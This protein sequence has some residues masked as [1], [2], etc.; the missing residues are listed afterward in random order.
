M[1]FRMKWEVTCI[2]Q[3]NSYIQHLSVDRY[4]FRSSPLTTLP[5]GFTPLM[6]ASYQGYCSV[7][8]TLLQAGAT[9]NTINVRYTDALCSTYVF[10]TEDSW[11]WV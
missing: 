9:V 5:D 8:R 7:V 1:T 2:L 4:Y 11:H 10:Q 6:A 3:C